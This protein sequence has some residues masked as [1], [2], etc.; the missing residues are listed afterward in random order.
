MVR[1][2]RSRR[3]PHAT[4][5]RCRSRSIN[6]REQPRELQLPEQ[7]GQAG[8]VGLSALQVAHVSAERYVFTQADQLA[9]DIDGVAARRD[10][11]TLLAFDLVRMV[12]HALDRAIPA[13]Q[14]GRSLG[15][16]AFDAGHVVHAVA[17]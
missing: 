1:R 8:S 16:D 4:S 3:A 13:N 5:L 10:G 17:H 14:V 11:L 7:L 6:L 9:R 15:P 2:R 12:N